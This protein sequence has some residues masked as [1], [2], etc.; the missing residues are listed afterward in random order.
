MW[1]FSLHVAMALLLPALAAV[2]LPAREQF[3]VERLE[4]RQL[5]IASCVTGSSQKASSLGTCMGLPYYA[6]YMQLEECS[7]I[8]SYVCLNYHSQL[9]TVNVLFLYSFLCTR[10]QE[11]VP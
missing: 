5:L 1:I 7:C 2:A 3:R 8:H 9:L 10:G 6:V 11:F 4:E